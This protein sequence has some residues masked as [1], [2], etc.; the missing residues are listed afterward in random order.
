M[1]SEDALKFP[2]IGSCVL[3][4]LYLLFR[5]LDKDYV[6]MLLT[7]YFLFFGV[8]AM[9]ASFRPVF[10][11]FFTLP[12][13]SWKRELRF[14][15]VKEPL[16]LDLDKVDFC[17][18]FVAIAVAT[19]YA[20]TKHWIANNILGLCF[21]VQG[22]AFISLGNYKT[23]CIL[24]GGL[25]VYD[26]WWVF[27]TDVMVTVAKSFDAPIKLLFPKDMFAAKLEFSMLGLGD[28]VIPGIFIALLLRFDQAQWRARHSAPQ[29]DQRFPKPYFYTCYL[30]YFLGLVATIVVMH[31]FKSAQPALLYLVPACISSSSV[32]ALMRG[33][34]YSLLNYVDHKDAA[35]KHEDADS[36][37]A[38]PAPPSEAP[39]AQGPSGP[40]DG[41]VSEVKQRGSS[42]RSK[43][44]K[45]VS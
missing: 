11:P 24:L 1:T 37:S 13:P 18:L 2:L 20:F 23:G 43:P 22:V 15:F 36:P 40:V 5:Y 6:N 16:K 27:G 17:A 45:L 34:F 25:F 35:K 33:E 21:S 38:L 30:G 28:I 29:S 31:L 3:G 42:K 32:L 8:I 4:G 14:P 9:Q 10:E 41:A 26:V 19:W 7:S 44:S 12:L 39:L